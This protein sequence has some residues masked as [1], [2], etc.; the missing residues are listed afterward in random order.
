MGA[1]A[2]VWEGGVTSV[3]VV[4]LDYL[5]R[6][7]VQLSVYCAR[8]IPVHLRWTQCSILLLLINICFLPYI[9]LWQIWQIQTCLCA[10]VGPGFVSTLPAFM[11]SSVPAICMASLN[12]NRSPFLGAGFSTQFAQRFARPL[13]QLHRE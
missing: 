12:K 4:S 5:F 8:R 13:S 1:W 11:R 10:F 9:C 7:Q 6:W 3:C 2:R